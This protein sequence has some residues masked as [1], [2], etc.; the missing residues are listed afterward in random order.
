VDLG[1]IHGWG[2]KKTWRR[3]SGISFGRGASQGEK[4]TN[5]EGRLP[6]RV[7][8]NYSTTPALIRV[9]QPRGGLERLNKEE[10]RDTRH[11]GEIVQK[12]RG[13]QQPTKGKDLKGEGG[14]GGKRKEIP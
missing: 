10:L 5:R 9:S 6:V 7:K 12:T 14:Y 3:R 4:K 13:F 2:K 11:R 1:R 8:G